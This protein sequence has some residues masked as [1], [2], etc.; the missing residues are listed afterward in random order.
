MCKKI[1]EHTVKTWNR[2]T[3]ADS[4]DLKKDNDATVI[5]KTG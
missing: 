3:K 2:C 1:T 5:L 4:A